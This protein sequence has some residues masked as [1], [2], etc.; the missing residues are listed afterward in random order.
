MAVFSAR[1]VFPRW[2]A[3]GRNLKATILLMPTMVQ[4][5]RSISRRGSMNWRTFS[6]NNRINRA[7]RKKPKMRPRI[8]AMTY[9]K[10]SEA[11][12]RSGFWAALSQRES[13]VFFNWW[14]FQWGPRRREIPVRRIR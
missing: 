6:P 4:W 12:L 14:M 13:A 10:N 9:W 2:R 7:I 1:P 3:Q 8:E 11:G 5:I